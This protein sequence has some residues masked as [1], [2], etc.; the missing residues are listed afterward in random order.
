MGGRAKK[1]TCRPTPARAYMLA[2]CQYLG[3]IFLSQGWSSNEPTFQGGVEWDG[4]S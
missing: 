2:E 1:D 3:R 4:M